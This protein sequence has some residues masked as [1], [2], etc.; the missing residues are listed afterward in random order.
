M[1]AAKKILVPVDFSD[2][3][4]AAVSAALQMA[5]A[6]GGEVW[7]LH[8]EAGLDD[9]IQDKIQTA[10]EGTAVSDAIDFDEASLI[11]AAKLEASRC[12]EAGRPLPFVPIHLRVTGGNWLEVAL[13]MIDELQLDLVVTGTH[14]RKGV[15]G[16]FMGSVSE[17]LVAKAPCSVFVVKPQGFPYLRD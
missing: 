12:A 1:Y 15:R 11:E 2:V 4:R 6:S 9:E 3:S 10:P 13:Q 14:G 16:F 5:A 7:L 17:R 8:V